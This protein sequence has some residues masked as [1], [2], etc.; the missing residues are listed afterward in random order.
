MKALSLWQPHGQAIALRMKLYETRG[1]ATS[2]RGPLMIHAAKKKFRIED[3]PQNYYWEVVG[4][5]MHAGLPLA[6]MDYGKMICVVDVVD[7]VPTGTLRGKIG[8]AE[9]WGD[10]RDVGD[11]GKRRFAFKLENL[12]VISPNKRPLVTGRQGFFNVPD[13]MMELL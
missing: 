1:W 6:C 3:Y 8:E 11:D 4:R 12:R 5:F 2:Y 7:C 9:F 10:F 13:T